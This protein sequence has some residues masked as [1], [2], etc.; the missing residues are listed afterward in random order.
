MNLYYATGACSLADRIALH[1]AGL[2]ATFERVDLRTKITE[3]GADFLAINL[4]G[5]VPAL[6]L[7]DGEIITENIAILAWIAGQAPRLAPAGSLGTVRLLEALAFVS[8]EIHKGFKP[9]FT[10]GASGA[11]RAKAG[12]AISGR[13]AFVATRLG[14]PYLFGARFTVADAYLFVTLRWARQSGVEVPRRT[15]GLSRADRGKKPRA[16]RAGRGRLARSRRTGRRSSRQLIRHDK[17]S[18]RTCFHA[19]DCPSHAQA[20]P[21]SSDSCRLPSS[22]YALHRPGKPVRRRQATRSSRRPCARP[23][24]PPPDPLPYR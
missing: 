18:R 19:S 21:D 1:E 23:P 16:H 12:D 24:R 22:R 6:V 5:Y 7:D 4:K 11:D 20:P 14:G 2:E 9:F 10:P 15:R 17:S 3:K 13:F 8:T